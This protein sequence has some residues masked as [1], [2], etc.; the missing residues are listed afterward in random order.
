MKSS[1]LAPPERTPSVHFALASFWGAG[2]LTPMIQLA[3][4][5]VAPQPWKPKTYVTLAVQVEA[6]TSSM[7]TVP[8]DNDRIRVLTTLVETTDKWF[9]NLEKKNIV[10]ADDFTP[11]V[12]TPHSQWPPIS[13]VI[14]DFMSG[15]GLI[16]A[17]RLRVPCFTFMASPL[18]VM[19][20]MGHFMELGLKR[21]NDEKEFT[22][23]GIGEFSLRR[24]PNEDVQPEMRAQLCQMIT[25]LASQAEGCLAN[26]ME[27]LYS[28]E[29]LA[30]LPCK[31]LPPRWKVLSCGPLVLHDPRLLTV[32]LSEHVEAFL[33]RWPERSVL[34]IALGS[35]WNPE[36][37]ELREMVEGIALS[38]RP[39][40]FAFR[41][42]GVSKSNGNMKSQELGLS[43]H[44]RQSVADRGLIIPWVNQPAVLGHKSI[45]AF[46][47][48]CGWNSTVETLALGGIPLLLLPLGAD[49]YNVSDF[50][51]R[52]LKCGRRIWGPDFTLTREQIRRDIDIVFND[53]EMAQTCQ[54][55]RS[56]VSIES[57]RKSELNLMKLY[58][59]IDHAIYKP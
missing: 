30:C 41:E 50:L 58:N 52:H 18:F 11:R 57:A 42:K 1:F 35:F 54:R 59:H 37:H 49:Q 27:C 36:P 48:H 17:K 44:F 21:K 10:A 28:E 6:N 15:F 29:Y 40:L 39:F 20:L 19:Y 2:H 51:E 45:G 26:D 23:P 33:N 53:L 16:L 13:I 46:M 22:I 43:E 12:S 38:G 3:H 9:E 7:V 5:L 25:E 56:L 55:L 34:Y 47:T 14:S 4:C 31:P 32:P 8:G 24:K